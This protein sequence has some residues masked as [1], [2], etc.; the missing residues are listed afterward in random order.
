[1]NY[2]VSITII[3]MIEV[4]LALCFNGCGKLQVKDKK[5]T[6]NIV[7]IQSPG[8]VPSQGG[9]IG[10][11]NWFTEV[12]ASAGIHFRNINGDP[13]QLPIIWTIMAMGGLISTS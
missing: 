13:E 1:M 8:L 6:L 11:P 9:P 4:G 5:K 3:L 10:A 12:T 2:K 7:T